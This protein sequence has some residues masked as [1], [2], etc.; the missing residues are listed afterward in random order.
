MTVRKLS[1]RSKRED[2]GGPQSRGFPGGRG[3]LRLSVALRGPRASS[4]LKACGAGA[5]MPFGTSL[6]TAAGACRD[7]HESGRRGQPCSGPVRQVKQGKQCET[8]GGPVGGPVPA[9]AKFRRAGTGT[10]MRMARAGLGCHTR[11]AASA[12]RRDACDDVAAGAAALAVAVVS[13]LTSCASLSGCGKGSLSC[14]RMRLMSAVMRRAIFAL[15]ASSGETLCS[16]H[17]R[18]IVASSGVLAE[19]LADWLELGDGAGGTTGLDRRGCRAIHILIRQTTS[20]TTMRSS[21]SGMGAGAPGPARSG[22][23]ASASVAALGEAH[24]TAGV[25]DRRGGMSI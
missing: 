22:S 24:I 17:T 10:R 7:R 1:T 9:R 6:G 14:D 23:G 2:H 15:S 4:V 13:A 25:Y 18:A 16:W 8:A 5:A 12:M 19:A 21:Q 20:W 3:R 11:Q